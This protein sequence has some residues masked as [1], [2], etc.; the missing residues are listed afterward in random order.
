MGELPSRTN[1]P[2]RTKADILD[3]ASREFAEKGLS[4]ASVNEIAQVTR[5]SK[6]MI[7]YYFG[8]KEGLYR[9]V[10]EENYRKLRALD[11]SMDLDKL[12]PLDAL[13][14]LVSVSFDFHHD[15]P[16]FVRLV[17]V[18]NIHHARHT[19]ELPNLNQLNI[20]A[21]ETLRKICNRGVEAGVIRSGIDPLALH[22]TISALCFHH[23]ANRYTLSTIFGN[24]MTSKA[25]LATRRQ[26]VIDTVVR[27]VA[28]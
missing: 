13:V 18:E 22:I 28:P 4:G 11:A 5:T 19:A 23:V 10:I 14:A 16:E 20:G 1:D 17:M 12:A 15:H 25:A 26:I 21:I 7:Y 9:K 2:E 3:V 24:D 27:Y 6:R 8:S